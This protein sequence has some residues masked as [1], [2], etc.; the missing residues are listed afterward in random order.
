[1][2]RLL[3]L[4]LIIYLFFKILWKKNKTRENSD[5]IEIEEEMKR[6]PVCGTYVPV[7]QAIKY[8]CKGETCYFCS[9]ECKEKFVN[10]NKS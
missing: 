6:D 9:D 8:K 4:I 2:I 5:S 7:S 10:S 3:L 1:M